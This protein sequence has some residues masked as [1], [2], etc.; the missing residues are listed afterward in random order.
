[1]KTRSGFLLLAAAWT[2]ASQAAHAREWT[3]LGGFDSGSVYDIDAASIA[4]TP[5]SPSR[6][7]PAQQVWFRDDSAKNPAAKYKAAEILISF[8]C[9]HYKYLI[10]R[11]IAYDGSGAVMGTTTTPDIGKQ[12]K[13][14]V[15]DMVPDS[16]YEFVCRQD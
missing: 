3:T 7:F 15:G 9:S 6:S 13:T 8:D 11:A 16:V 12:Y 10:L 5:K 4:P 2:A 14:I 1:M